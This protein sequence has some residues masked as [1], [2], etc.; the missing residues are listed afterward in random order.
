[1]NDL[2]V[3]LAGRPFDHMVY[4]L[5]LTYSNWETATICFSESF[6]SLSQG[7]QNALWELGGVPQ[8]HRTDRLS[9]AV[10]NTPARNDLH[11]RP[12]SPPETSLSGGG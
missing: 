10:N 4:H 7:L 5:V 8:M 2:H 1:M 9:A 11:G 12:L 6:E 3:T